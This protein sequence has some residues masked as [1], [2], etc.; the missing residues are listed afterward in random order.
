MYIMRVKQRTQNLMFQQQET[1]T[2][3][4]TQNKKKRIQEN[5]LCGKSF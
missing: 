5:S 4:K 1:K 2:K 3:T